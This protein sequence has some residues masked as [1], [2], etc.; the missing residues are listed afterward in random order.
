MPQLA[1]MYWGA[2][3]ILFYSYLGYAALVW[4]ML[5]IRRIFSI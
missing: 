1:I 4:T 5:R 3:G 2:L